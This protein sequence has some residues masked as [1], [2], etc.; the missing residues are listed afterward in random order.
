VLDPET[1]VQGKLLAF[2]ISVFV[3]PRFDTNLS[4]QSGNTRDVV[5]ELICSL[6]K[7]ISLIGVN[8]HAKTQLY[9]FSSSEVTALNEIIVYYSLDSDNSHD[10]RA[11]IGAIVEIPLVLV[12]LL[13]PELL[14]NTLHRSWAKASP[15]QLR[16]HLQDLGLDTTG[17]KD[18]LR[19]RL[20]LAL[21]TGSSLRRLPKVISLE[22][23]IA[24]LVAMVGPGY[25]TMQSCMNHLCGVRPFPS[26]DELYQL[27][28]HNDVRLGMKLSSRSSITYSIVTELRR[29]TSSAEQIDRILV[30]D[31]TPL[32]PAYPVHCQDENLRK[33]MFMHEV[34][35]LSRANPV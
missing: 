5:E 26:D 12:G 30:N 3:G 2:D 16:H 17:N 1:S 11:C 13:Q 32:N 34:R 18:T 14:G 19:E 10:I 29:R 22:K 25:T 20:Q 6:S 8:S 31:A 23:A 33:L 7:I 35:S 4:R 27:A 15:E 21:N 24:D 9:C 28:K